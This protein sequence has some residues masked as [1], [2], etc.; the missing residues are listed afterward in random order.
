MAWTPKV[1]VDR[2]VQFPL[3]R[4]LT[5]VPGQ[6]N[7]FDIA[8]AEG[9]IFVVGDEP[10]AANLNA[11]FGNV[12][13]E[14]DSINTNLTVVTGT[15]SIS[16]TSITI[17]DSRITTDSVLDFYTSIYGVNPLTVTVSTGQVV[18]TF[19]AQTV[20]MTVGVRING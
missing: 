5:A 4:K 17:T 13:T 6:V 16:A 10:D 11:E 8:R 9:T 19:P 15:L 20:A 18:L 7:T 2:S 14:L 12:K 3:R 1:W